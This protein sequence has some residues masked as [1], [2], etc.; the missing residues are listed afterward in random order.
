MYSSRSPAKPTFLVPVIEQNSSR[1]NLLA[2]WL[3]SILPGVEGDFPGDGLWVSKERDLGHY[4][5]PC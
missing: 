1:F 3:R 4:L 2:R 5:I